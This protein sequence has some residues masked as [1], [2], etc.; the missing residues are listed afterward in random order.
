MSGDYRQSRDHDHVNRR[1]SGLFALG[2]GIL[3]LALVA[4]GSA[5][6]FPLT[7]TAQLDL[8]E[9]SAADVERFVPGGVD[10]SDSADK[11]SGAP[12]LCEGSRPSRLVGAAIVAVPNTLS[13]VSVLRYEFSSG[14]E[15]GAYFEALRSQVPFVRSGSC[16]AAA[17]DSGVFSAVSL[18]AFQGTGVAD[19]S[20]TT[21]FPTSLYVGRQYNVIRYLQQGSAAYIIRIDRQT[22]YAD[23]W[24]EDAIERMMNHGRAMIPDSRSHSSKPS[25]IQGVLKLGHYECCQVRTSPTGPF[26]VYPI[27]P[28]LVITGTPYTIAFEDQ[29]PNAQPAGL[30]AFSS[31]GGPATTIPWGANV[32]A[33][34][35]TFGSST[36]F[37]CYLDGSKTTPVANVLSV[38]VA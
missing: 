31:S 19:A 27:C 30:V 21:I 33:V 3:L 34:V 13:Q 2:A 9:P 8:R 15:A 6:D 5:Q 1:C 37:G 38:T 7:P 18:F 4:C 26:P 28:E 23:I 20:G 32:Y 36:S 22:Q 24:F 29:L 12:L 16:R 10:V 35:D 11:T 14:G 17:K 25:Q